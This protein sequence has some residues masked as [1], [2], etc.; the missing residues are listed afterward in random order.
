MSANKQLGILAAVACLLMPA[1]AGASPGRFATAEAE[2]AARLD[3][4]L[5][6]IYAPDASRTLAEQEARVRAA[7]EEAFSYEAM[8]RRSFG[9]HWRVLK[10]DEKAQ[11]RELMVRLL[12]RSYLQRFGAGNRPVLAY[13]PAIVL[14]PGR[15]EVPSTATLDGQTFSLAY[16][17]LERD[18]QREVYDVIIE[19]VSL[20]GNFREQI[21][22]HF[23]RGNAAGLIE[24][25]ERQLAEL[26]ATAAPAR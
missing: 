11:L 7:M 24:R 25:L 13:R 21:D 26:E 16:R 20:V 2:V 14:A 15:L 1:F 10:A 9:R 3:T 8:V 19:G 4:V 5:S 22:A 18:G 23:Q 12:V 6:A 17:L